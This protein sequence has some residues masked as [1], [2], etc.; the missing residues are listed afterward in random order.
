MLM[1]R[2]KNQVKRAVTSIMIFILKPLIIPILIIVTLLIIACSITDIFYISFNNE[3]EIDMKKEV[4]YY[5]EKIEYS[6]EEMK[7]FLSSVW[8]FIEK[9]FDEGEMSKETDW[10]VERILYNNKW[11]WKK[12]C[13]NGWC[14]YIS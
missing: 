14:I 11:I 9:I 5:D 6:K 2:K 1:D 4:K 10:P 3:D 8:D 13:S 12:K 7:G